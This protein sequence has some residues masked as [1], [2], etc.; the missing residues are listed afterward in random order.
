VNLGFK[1]DTPMKFEYVMDDVEEGEEPDIE[2]V[3]Y[4]APKIIDD[5]E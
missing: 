2:L 1:K 3:F 4:L 5:A